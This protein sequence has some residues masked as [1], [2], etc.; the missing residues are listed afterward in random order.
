MAT[1]VRDAGDYS[2]NAPSQGYTPSRWRQT[3][4]AAVEPSPRGGVGSAGA[5]AKVFSERGTSIAIA[6][7]INHVWSMARRVA[8]DLPPLDPIPDQ[9]ALVQRFLQTE[10]GAD[11]EL[12]SMLGRGVAV[13]H[14]GLSD[15]VRSLVEWLAEEQGLRVLPRQRPSP[16]A[17]TFP[18]RLS[19][20]R[21]TSTRTDTR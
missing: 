4:V 7:N 15:E 12:I 17:S 5:M 2:Q 1:G 21:R 14:A 6:T 8:M 11:F 16:R 13:H 19:F 10:I 3:S 18:Y 20:W 9:V